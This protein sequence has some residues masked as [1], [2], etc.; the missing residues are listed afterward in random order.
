MSNYM[1]RYPVNHHPLAAVVLA[2]IPGRS[3]DWTRD[4]VLHMADVIAK[5]YGIADVVQARPIAVE[6]HNA[7]IYLSHIERRSV[8]VAEM[9]DAII[10]RTGVVR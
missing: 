1:H 10:A 2:S 3:Q 4:H 8:I 9:I 7:G 5:W 6:L